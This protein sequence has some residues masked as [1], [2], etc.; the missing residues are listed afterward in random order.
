MATFMAWYSTGEYGKL[1]FEAENIDEARELLDRVQRG[2]ISV[3]EL[4]GFDS[5]IKGDGWEFDDLHELDG[6]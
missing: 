6:E 1:W 5:S 4:P 3:D 2:E